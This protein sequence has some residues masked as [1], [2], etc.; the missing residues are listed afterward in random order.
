MLDGCDT[1]AMQNSY[2]V[3]SVAF[4]PDENSYKWFRN[5]QTKIGGVEGR[6]LAMHARQK[7]LVSSVVIRMWFSKGRWN[8]FFAHH[9]WLAY[10][11]KHPSPAAEFVVKLK[12]NSIWKSQKSSLHHGAGRNGCYCT[13]PKRNLPLL[14]TALHSI[15]SALFTHDF[16]KEINCID[17]PT[18]KQGA[19]VWGPCMS[20]LFERME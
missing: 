8:R 15:D 3:M 7:C 20:T 12:R 19:L 9:A 18:T 1:Y 5:T 14:C 16:L 13:P 4:I 11:K 2:N 17:L 10:K 6:I